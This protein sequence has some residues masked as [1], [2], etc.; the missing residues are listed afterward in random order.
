MDCL[1]AR[2]SSALHEPS[3]KPT[4]PGQSH[5]TLDNVAGVPAFAGG[6]VS[7]RML[8]RKAFAEDCV[9][10]HGPGRPRSGSGVWGVAPPRRASFARVAAQKSDRTFGGRSSWRFFCTA[11]LAMYAR[12]FF[13]GWPL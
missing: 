8:D 9:A 7:Q 6:D 4:S 5:V 10:P 12:R 3:L 11:S 2:P 1:A 13:F